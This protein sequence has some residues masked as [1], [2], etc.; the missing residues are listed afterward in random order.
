MTD[1]ELLAL[2]KEYLFDDCAMMDVTK[3][4]LK[5]PTGSGG[6]AV[7]TVHHSKGLEY[8]VVIGLDQ[9]ASKVSIQSLGR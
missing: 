2:A 1:Q 3:L 8:P 6:V 9:L 7:M 5:R 4:D